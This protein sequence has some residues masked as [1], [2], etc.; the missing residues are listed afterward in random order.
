MQ[1]E[2]HELWR[3]LRRNDDVR[4]IV[5]TGAGDKA[6]CTGIDRA[7]TMGDYGK[8]DA[9]KERVVGART[10]F[11]FDDPGRTSGRRAAIS[12]SR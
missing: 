2:L 8:A 11:M 10:P 12:G 6:F 5:L 3:G 1:G 7:E 4:C 9:K